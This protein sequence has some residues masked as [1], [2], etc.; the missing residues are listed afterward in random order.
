[1]GN[2]MLRT[3]HKILLVTFLCT[4]APWVFASESASV[5]NTVSTV[6]E[7]THPNTCRYIRNILHEH[8][9]KVRNIVFIVG[10][11]VTVQS[12][13]TM[14]LI[15]FS[16][17]DAIEIE[18]KVID[19]LIQNHIKNHMVSST[20][21]LQRIDWDRV[22]MGVLL[23]CLVVISVHLYKIEKTMHRI[24]SQIKSNTLFWI[25][26]LPNKLLKSVSPQG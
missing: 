11:N 6:S 4:M 5:E 12:H 10:S 9:D 20:S 13:E 16:W 2:I 19:Q 3:M 1:M 23:S 24:D 21:L 26:T 25:C 18:D 14:L 15:P 7:E 22:C 17:I 8:R